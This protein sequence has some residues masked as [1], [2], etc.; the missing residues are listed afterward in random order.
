M[1]QSQKNRWQCA[2]E[3]LIYKKPDL[4]HCWDEREEQRRQ[5]K[6]WRKTFNIKRK[7][8]TAGEM[9]QLYAGAQMAPS[10]KGRS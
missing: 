3:G 6:H 10:R 7:K 2:K 4:G 1:F 8:N 9:A 5:K